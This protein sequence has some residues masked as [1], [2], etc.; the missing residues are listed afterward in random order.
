M[1]FGNCV[2]RRADSIQVGEKVCFNMPSANYVVTEIEHTKI[3]MIRHHQEGGFEGKYNSYWP[4][5]LL[6]VEDKTS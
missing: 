6:Y 5:E 2:L 4:E 3:G 1:K